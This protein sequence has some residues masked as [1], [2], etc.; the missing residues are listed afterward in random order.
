[1]AGFS[2]ARTSGTPFSLRA[3]RTRGRRSAHFPPV[4]R[5]VLPGE[6]ASRHGPQPDADDDEAFVEENLKVLERTDFKEVV[7]TIFGEVFSCRYSCN[8]VVIRP[9]VGHFRDAPQPVQ[10]RTAITRGPHDERDPGGGFEDPDKRSSEYSGDSGSDQEV[11]LEQLRKVGA[12]ITLL[13]K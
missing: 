12:S 3:R 13:C 1:M 4:E 6:A 8:S 10:D 7:R 5:L 2:S 9:G 11:L